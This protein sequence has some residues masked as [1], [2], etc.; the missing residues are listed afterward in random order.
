MILCPVLMLVQVGMES[1][2]EGRRGMLKKIPGP[3]IWPGRGEQLLKIGME[4]TK[5]RVERIRLVE[6]I[7]EGKAGIKLIRRVIKR[8]TR[9]VKVLK[10]EGGK[11]TI[12]IPK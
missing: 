6:E 8:E 9:K 4:R 1:L 10:K 12:K 3:S 7:G 5:G 2:W 11:K